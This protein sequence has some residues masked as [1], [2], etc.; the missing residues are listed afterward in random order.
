ELSARLSGLD[1]SRCRLL[2][3]LD[4]DGTLSELV[5]MPDQAVL[6]AGTRR[7][8]ARLSRRPDT[9]VAVISGRAL[10]DVRSR[11]ALPGLYY[12]GNHG[13]EI[14]GPGIRWTHPRAAGTDAAFRRELDDDFRDFPGALVEHKRLGF[15]VHY[16]GVPPGELPRLR[17]RLKARLPALTRRY[18]LLRAKKTY[19]FRLDVPWGKGDALRAIRRTLKGAWSAM[20]VGDDAT[21]EEAFAAIGPRAL[22]VRIGRVED[23]AAQYV[24]P[25]RAL[26]DRLL[27]GLTR[28]P[29][30]GAPPEGGH[31]LV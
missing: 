10:D 3:A 1:F 27:D 31:E 15:A 17:R 8:L 7:L 4:F 9:K 2:V 12:A 11:V 6:A 16:R 28:R 26:V 18:R 19:D 25:R 21:D 13:L 14:D 29:G 23:S 22:T 5:T 24:L 30:A 20:F